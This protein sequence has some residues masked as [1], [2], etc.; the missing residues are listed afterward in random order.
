MFT[1]TEIFSAPARVD[2]LRRELVHLFERSVKRGVEFCFFLV[3]T[4]LRG[5]G[6]ISVAALS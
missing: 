3:L 4:C 2:Q 6:E 1:A 5:A